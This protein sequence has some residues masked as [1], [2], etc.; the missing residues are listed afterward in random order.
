MTM[1]WFPDSK[2]HLQS[3]AYDYESKMMIN[4][5]I[6]KSKRKLY[7]VDSTNESSLLVDS[8]ADL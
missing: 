8:T 5:Y 4:I 1:W 3:Q 7:I 6:F 2:S